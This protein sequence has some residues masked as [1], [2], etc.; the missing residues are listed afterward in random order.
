MGIDD[1][2]KVK[3]ET[4]HGSIEAIAWLTSGVRETTVFVPIG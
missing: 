4:A 3:V 1:G 2:A